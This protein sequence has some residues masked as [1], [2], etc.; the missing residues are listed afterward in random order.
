MNGWASRCSR[1]GPRTPTD[2]AI[3]ESTFGSINTLFC[4]HVAGYTGSNTTLRGAD[5]TGAWTLPE[6]Q[7]LLDEWLIVGWQPRPHDAL[8][9]PH[10]AAAGAVAEREVRR[11]GR[12]GRLP[13]ADAVR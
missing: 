11:A 4:Q 1:P 3:V 7:D 8:R 12:R 2:K 10:V 9:D 6:L 13:A 5:A